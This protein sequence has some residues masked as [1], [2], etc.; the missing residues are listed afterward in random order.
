MLSEIQKELPKPTPEQYNKETLFNLLYHDIDGYQIAQDVEK[1]LESE[2]TYTL[3]ITY[4]E[5]N[6][7][8]FQTLLSKLCDSPNSTFYDLGSGIGK[9]VFAAALLGPFQKLVGIE[10]IKPLHDVAV[11]VK[12]QFDK[13]MNQN[14]D[15]VQFYNGDLFDFDFSDG[16]VIFSATTC[17]SY[18]SMV[19]L[20]KKVACMKKGAKIVTLTNQL[21]NVDGLFQLIEWSRMVYGNS[22][23]LTYF[24][25]KRL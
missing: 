6:F 16:D 25:Y 3:S 14:P 23:N 1:V 8:A 12:S 7:E 2:G 17:F 5:I 24:I 15:R 9:A 22:L 4:G 21:E 11:Q 10:I 19:N 20:S 18:Q 13:E